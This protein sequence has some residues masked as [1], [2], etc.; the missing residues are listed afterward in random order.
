[1]LIIHVSACI[2]RTNSPSNEFHRA[3][4]FMNQ[5]YSCAEGKFVTSNSRSST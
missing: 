1:M 4:C 3:V 2:D 5:L